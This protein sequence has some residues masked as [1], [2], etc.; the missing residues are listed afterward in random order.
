MVNQQINGVLRTIPGKFELHS[1]S[2]LGR[3]LNQ[4]INRNMRALPN[5]SSYC[6]NFQSTYQQWIALALGEIWALFSVSDVKYGESTDQRGSAHCT[7]LLMRLS[8][9]QRWIA[10]ALGKIWGFLSASWSSTRICVLYLAFIWWIRY[11][12]FDL[13]YFK[14]MCQSKFFFYINSLLKFTCSIFVWI[15]LC[16]V[17]V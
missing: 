14:A 4:Q 12:S 7:F 2:V 9:Y 15:T 5:F 3:M 16:T 17:W 11:V 1:R 10:L 8:A 13:N 6:F